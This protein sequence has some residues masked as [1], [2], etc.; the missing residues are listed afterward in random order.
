MIHI[1][2]IFIRISSENSD[3]PVY[4]RIFHWLRHGSKRIDQLIYGGFSWSCL[5]HICNM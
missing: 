5:A 1:V 2:V 3:S 4:N